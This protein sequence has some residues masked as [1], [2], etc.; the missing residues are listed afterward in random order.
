MGMVTYYVKRTS[1]FEI[2]HT[3]K[4]D[5]QLYDRSRL[6]MKGVLKDPEDS[7]PY[8]NSD[9]KILRGALQE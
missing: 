6:D 3:G 1:L 9:S 4:H 7:F 2:N 5:S 8:N